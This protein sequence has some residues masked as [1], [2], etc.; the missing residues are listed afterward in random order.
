MV[1]DSDGERPKEDKLIDEGPR[2]PDVRGDGS[3]PTRR[4]YY[5]ASPRRR[6]RAGV[7]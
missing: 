1:T 3:T 7:Y 5:V 4:G 6:P 2:E